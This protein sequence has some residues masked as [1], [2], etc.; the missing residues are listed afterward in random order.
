MKLALCEAVAL[1]ATRLLFCLS[2]ALSIFN[3]RQRKVDLRKAIHGMAQKNRVEGVDL[4]KVAHRAD[5]RSWN[6]RCG[7]L[8]VFCVWLCI[9]GM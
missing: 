1:T 6:V 5:L 2:V 7:K 9:A 8:R 4:A 3:A